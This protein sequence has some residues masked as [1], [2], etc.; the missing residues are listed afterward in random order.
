M[1][2]KKHTG[3]R[4]VRICLT[5]KEIDAVR[6]LAYVDAVAPAVVAVV[7]KAIKAQHSS[8]DNEFSGRARPSAVKAEAPN[9]D[10]ETS[11]HA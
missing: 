8:V 1:E 3:N 2:Y 10:A 4:W 7:R 9:G 5:K 11:A 6:R